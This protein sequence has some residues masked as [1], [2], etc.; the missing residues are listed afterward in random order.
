MPSGF[1]NVAL[2]PHICPDVHIGNLKANIVF[3]ESGTNVT[4]VMVKAAEWFLDD[5]TG[6]VSGHAG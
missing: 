6:F 2:C 1:N 3:D 4:I 5:Y